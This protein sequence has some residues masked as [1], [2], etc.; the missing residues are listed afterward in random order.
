MWLLAIIIAW[1]GSSAPVRTW[2][3]LTP[4]PS[5]RSFMTCMHDRYSCTWIPSDD[6]C[7]SA[8][9]TSTGTTQWC[10][11]GTI[12][13]GFG[14]YD[15]YKNLQTCAYMKLTRPPTW[16]FMLMIRVVLEIPPPAPNSFKISHGLA[17]CGT[18]YEQKTVILLGR[19]D[20]D[21]EVQE[22]IDTY[23]A[24]NIDRTNLHTRWQWW[25]LS[26]SLWCQTLT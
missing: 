25:R 3:S 20:N 12:T 10:A 18:I 7:A 22:S 5:S 4:T 23:L 6:N 11:L 9:T 15:F 19:K 16:F 17:S 14:T 1:S 8:V 24:I 2:S 26:L 21:T 13:H